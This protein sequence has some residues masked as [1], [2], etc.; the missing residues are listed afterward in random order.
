VFVIA[1]DLHFLRKTI[2]ARGESASFIPFAISTIK[3]RQLQRHRSS[4]RQLEEYVPDFIERA[5]AFGTFLSVESSRAC[6][7][8]IFLV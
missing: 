4:V 1:I 5:H 3:A 8:S 7:A 2:V 6:N